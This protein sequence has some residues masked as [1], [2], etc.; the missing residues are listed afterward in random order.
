M[1][2]PSRARTVEE[3]RE[4]GRK[5]AAVIRDGGFVG[6]GA[7][8]AGIPESTFYSWLTGTDEGAV[9]FQLEVMPAYYSAA[10][11][12]EKEALSDIDG[13]DRGP[14]GPHSSFHK[15]R[16]EKRWPKAFATPAQLEVS[17]PGGKPI[18]HRD[19]REMATED[20]VAMVAGAKD[21]DE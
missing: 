7:L 9:A 13:G 17:G 10:G 5:A 18:E 2:G 3:M 16:L 1:A 8:A 12:A 20:L 4:L 11:E 6:Q 19:V 15:W 21:E 14:S